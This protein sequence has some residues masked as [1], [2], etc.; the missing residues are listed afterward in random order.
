MA[1]P[2]KR[3]LQLVYKVINKFKFKFKVFQPYNTQILEPQGRQ[4]E[5]I[6]LQFTNFAYFP[7]WLGIRHG[8]F[9]AWC[10]ENFGC[11]WSGPDIFGPRQPSAMGGSP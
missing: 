11:W 9:T 5:H 1:I 7:S 3:V 8:L 4:S 10:K 2:Y 6:L